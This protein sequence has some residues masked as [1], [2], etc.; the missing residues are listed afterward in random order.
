ML[1]CL[2]CQSLDSKI[3]VYDYEQISVYA[4]MFDKAE[5]KLSVNSLLPTGGL[6]ILSSILVCD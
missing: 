5:L 1:H 4:G 3:L 6:L 2:R